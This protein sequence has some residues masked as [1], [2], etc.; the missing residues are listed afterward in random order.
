MASQNKIQ[1]HNLAERAEIYYLNPDFALVEQKAP[2]MNF[3]FSFFTQFLQDFR[4]KQI[5]HWNSISSSGITTY[6]LSFTILTVSYLFLSYL[7][8]P[9]CPLH[10]PNL[11]APYLSSLYFWYPTCPRSSY[12]VLPVHKP[13]VLTVYL[14][15]IYDIKK[16]CPNPMQILL[17]LSKTLLVASYR[18]TTPLLVS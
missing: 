5:V 11:M 15:P 18:S 7:W 17:F 9:T 2:I 6:Y 1:V 14:S 12:G 16:N 3:E 13:T 10:N 8:R 4:Q